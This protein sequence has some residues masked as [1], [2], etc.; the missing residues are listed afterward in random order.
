MRIFQLKCLFAFGFLF[1]AE[2]Y[3]II[4][5]DTEEVFVKKKRYLKE[6]MGSIV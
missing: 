1:C 6:N 2:K 5:I 4:D 3:F